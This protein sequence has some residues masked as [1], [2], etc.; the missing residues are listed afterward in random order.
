MTDQEI[1]DKF[2]VQCAGRIAPE[3]VDAIAKA[4]WSLA[5]MPDCARIAALALGAAG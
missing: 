2:R 5:D 4:V 1:E 3:D